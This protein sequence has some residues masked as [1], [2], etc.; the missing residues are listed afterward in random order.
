[1]G[2]NQDCSW[3]KQTSS[4]NHRP[5]DK[6][7]KDSPKHHNTT[8]TKPLGPLIPLQ[9]EMGEGYTIRIPHVMVGALFENET[10]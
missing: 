9:S 8:S 4:T 5:N 7:E 2:D 10:R 6:E 1:L 3:R